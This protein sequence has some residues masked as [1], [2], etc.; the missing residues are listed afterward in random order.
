MRVSDPEVRGVGDAGEGD[1]G[2]GDGWRHGGGEE[3]VF[4]R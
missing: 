1:A 4:V 2:E 3:G